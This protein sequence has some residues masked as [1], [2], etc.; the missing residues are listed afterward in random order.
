MKII[1]TYGEKKYELGFTRAS[2]KELEEKGFSLGDAQD[3]KMSS[4]FLLVEGAFRTYQPKI[5]DEEIWE[6]WEKL[7]KKELYPALIEL[8]QEPLKVLDDPDKKEQGNASW[9]MEK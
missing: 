2:I 6:V 3:E 5:S 9:K 4:I 7:P 8:F 1:I